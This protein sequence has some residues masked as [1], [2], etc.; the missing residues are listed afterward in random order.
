MCENTEN[1]LFNAAADR[2]AMRRFSC[3]IGAAWRRDAFLWI[4]FR[5]FLEITSQRRAVVLRMCIY[6]RRRENGA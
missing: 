6:N 1:N 5:I 2:V 4:I 3:E